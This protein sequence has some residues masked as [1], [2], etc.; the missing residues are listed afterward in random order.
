MEIEQSI[1]TTSEISAKQSLKIQFGVW[2][3]G[4]GPNKKEVSKKNP[5]RN[6]QRGLLFGTGEYKAIDFIFAN[7]PTV[8]LT[9]TFLFLKKS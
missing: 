3:G 2:G 7:Q 4:W 5:K 8:T 9:L 1:L 6:K